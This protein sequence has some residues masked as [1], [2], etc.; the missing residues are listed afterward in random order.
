MMMMFAFYWTNMLSWLTE[1]S[2][3][4]D[5]SLHS[6][7]LSWFGA[8]QSLLLLLNVQC[9]AKKQQKPVSVFGLTWLRCE[10]MIYRSQGEHVG[11]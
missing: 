11:V 9:L 3:W 6:H 1:T 7:T 4:V 10:P 2:P 8:N 5:I